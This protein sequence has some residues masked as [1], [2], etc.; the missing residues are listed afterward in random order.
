MQIL[1]DSRSSMCKEPF[2]CVEQNAVLSIR[3][4]VKDAGETGVFFLLEKDGEQQKTFSMMD[5]GEANGYR[6]YSVQ[7]AI[8]EPGLYFYCFR[9]CFK[10][11]AQIV[12]RDR[13]NQPC[14]GEGEEWQLTCYDGTLKAPESFYGQV[15]YQIFPDRFHRLGICDT[16]EKLTPFY[17]HENLSERPVYLPDE[18]GR[19]LNNDFFGGN[20]AGII[21]KLPYLQSLGVRVI[22]LNPIFMAFSNH[23]YDTADYLRVD[24][25]LGTNDDFK[26]LCQV[27]HELGIRII[28]DGVFS[29]TG[30]DSLYFDILNRFGGGAYHNKDSPYREWYQFQEYPHKYTS[31]WG[32]DTLPCTEEN[33]LSYQEFIITGKDSVIRY[34]L[35][36]GADGW[37]LDVAD[38]LPDEFLFS[39]YETVKSEKPDSLVLGEVWE[40]ASNKISY[41]RRR[42]YLQGGCLDG[43]MNYV[44]RD[45]IIRFVCGQMAAEDFCEAVMR[46]C[47]NYPEPALHT[48]MNLL[49]THDTPRILTVLGATTIPENR[50]ERGAYCL[51]EKERETGKNRLIL[52]LFLQFVLPGS[53][54]IY[55]GDEIGMEGFE[56]P[57]NRC[58]MGNQSVDF[59]ILEQY[60]NLADLKNK[61]LALRKGSL[62]TAFVG[63]GIFAFYRIYESERVFCLVN[64]TERPFSLPLSGGRVLYQKNTEDTKE[65]L[66]LL[67]YGCVAIL[68]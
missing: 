47:E 27:A 35:R 7:M 2:G 14:C 66:W 21:E 62:E 19:V 48:M 11:G 16:K 34:W 59:M 13:W 24:P 4:Y 44:W 22:Y 6:I 31:W 40:D 42:H 17:L 58:F 29:H 54:S 57:F 52:A 5:G 63:E 8:E 36:Q 26:H 37:R 1:F 45:A 55:Y 28:L 38:E 51:S 61:S 3:F 10:E 32:I 46:L 30:S 43:V 12:L 9:I 64:R 25:L 56:D 33:N 60:R 65:G 23:R 41:G 18:H 20:L 15:M 49:S 67:P 53:V 68:Q 39:L 50:E